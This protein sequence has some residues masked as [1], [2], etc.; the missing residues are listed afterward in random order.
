MLDHGSGGGDLDQEQVQVLGSSA[1]TEG[2]EVPEQLARTLGVKHSC[3]AVL[4]A[5]ELVLP[6]E[7]AG[8]WV[9]TV[10]GSRAKNSATAQ[11][12]AVRAG[13]MPIVSATDA[14][15][16]LCAP[17]LQHRSDVP[18]YPLLVSWDISASHESSRAA[19]RQAYVKFSCL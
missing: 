8:G 13:A 6:P 16:R 11:T 19:M 14:A 18:E 12:I 17:A 15:L 10:A 1:H 3:R 9:R 2:A 5:T 4:L 7:A